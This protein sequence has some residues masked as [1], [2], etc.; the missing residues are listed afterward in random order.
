MGELVK[1]SKA[2]QPLPIPT[3]IWTDISM[4]FIVGLPKA[5]NKSIIVVVPN[6]LLKYAHFCALS[7][8][9]RPS[10]VAQVF[11]D[12]IFQLDGMSISNFHCL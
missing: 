12:Q 7:Q 4:D 3:H 10:L 9:F 11:M 1:L 8:P 2:L 6:C 5:G